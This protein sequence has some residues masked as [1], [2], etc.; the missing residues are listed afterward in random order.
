V[1]QGRAS[2]FPRR[3]DQLGLVQLPRRGPGRLCRETQVQPRLAR[4]GPGRLGRETRGP[5]WLGRRPQQQPGRG[6]GRL[7]RET[8][9]PVHRWQPRRGCRRWGPW[10]R[11]K[12][13]QRPPESALRGVDI[14]TT[15]TP[16]FPGVCPTAIGAVVVYKIPSRGREFIHHHCSN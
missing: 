15:T 6:P 3:G 14:Y 11:H 10:W 1:S 5:L 9:W 2:L 13:Q 4:R 8:R 7:G 16:M 12:R